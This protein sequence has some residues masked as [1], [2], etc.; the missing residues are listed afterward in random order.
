MKELIEFFS[1]IV[2]NRSEIYMDITDRVKPGYI[3]LSPKRET[4]FFLSICACG[5]EGNVVV[6][7]CC[8]PF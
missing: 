2:Q 5:R 4:R 1:E 3:Y 8:F 7:N 6:Y